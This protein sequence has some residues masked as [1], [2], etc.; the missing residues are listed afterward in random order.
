MKKLIFL[1]M[2][3]LCPLYSWATAAELTLA[4]SQ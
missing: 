3:V 4:M 2:L 1:C